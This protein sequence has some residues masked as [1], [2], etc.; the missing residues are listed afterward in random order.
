MSDARKRRWQV[1]V[2]LAVV[3]A[4]VAVPIGFGG[5]SGAA[6]S[7]K[8][9]AIL[10]NPFIGNDWRPQMQKYAS[11]AV[12]KPPLAAR[13]NGVRIVTTQNND[14]ALQAPALQSAILESP[15]VI[16][17]IAASQTATN[18]LI[19]Q[20]CA[21][22]ITVVGFDTYP[23]APCAW[24]YAPDWTAVG[25]T[26]ADWL[27]RSIG[28]EGKIFVD[29]GVPG[30]AG[31]I[32]Q[33]KGIDS[34]LKKHPKVKVIEY[35]GKFSPGEETKA[36]NQLLAAHPDVKG[37]LS[38]AYGAQDSLRK[39]K[40][41]I[42]ATGF[43]YPTTMATC[44]QRNN[45]CLLV[46]VPPWISAEALKLATDIKSGKVKGKPR[47]V[48]F[49]VPVFVQNTKIKPLKKNIGSTYSLAKELRRAPKGAFLP[50]SPPWVKIDF[51]KEIQG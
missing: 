39:A 43:T 33:N 47:F 32:L 42:P 21:K 6:Q 2:A 3:V 41:R 5:N 23:T 11:A 12:A 4:A 44:V 16:V 19:A 20:A 18:G 22:G 13:Y 26:W 40:I 9:D 7:G 30:N 34:V 48:P 45:P 46:G 27:V 8:L 35:L 31:S 51:Q 24:K 37:I 1:S 14:P 25:R 10:L 50:S 38:T 29:R 49:P 36:V 17:M 15:D 28:G